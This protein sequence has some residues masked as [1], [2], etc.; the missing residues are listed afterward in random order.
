[1]SRPATS[2]ATGVLQGLGH[3]LAAV[4]GLAVRHGPEILTAFVSLRTEAEHFELMEHEL[5]GSP[6]FEFLRWQSPE[7]GRLMA[8]T[9]PSRAVQAHGWL[10]RLLQP[11]CTSPSFLDELD[12]TA[13]AAPAGFSREEFREGLVHV[14]RCELARAVV[15]LTV[16]LEGMIRESAVHAGSLSR[17]EADALRSGSLLV[18]RIWE[19]GDPYGPYM[20]KVVFGMANVYRHGI[21]P[22]WPEAQAVHALCGAAIWA[23]HAISDRRALVLLQRSLEL[24][25]PSAFAEGRLALSPEAQLRMIRAADKA[26]R[27]E[28]VRR[29]LALRD[30]LSELREQRSANTSS[31]RS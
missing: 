10:A 25:V 13:A 21:D 29:L 8:L 30:A 5:A 23:A 16:G 18:G 11:G 20:K 19:Q 15:P 28:E 12:R 7:V 22:G 24:A 6:S 2:L 26:E 31:E 4:G 27:S 17:S 14:E 1:M 9:A 3:S